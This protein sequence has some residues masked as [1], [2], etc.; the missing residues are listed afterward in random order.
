M[1]RVP[2]VEVRGATKTF[3]AVRALRAVDFAVGAGEIVGLIG[4]N[5]A[6]K[7][8]LVRVLAGATRPDGGDL[9][10]DGAPAAFHSPRDA[11]AAGIALVPQEI[12]LIG[13]QSVAD[14]IFL[15]RPFARRGI[16]NDREMRGRARE[17][18]ARVGLAEL[19]PRRP[20]RTLTPVQQKLV[21]FAQALSVDPR[22]LILD[23]P[24]AALPT[25]IARQ[26]EPVVSET[27]RRGSGVIY[28]SHRLDEISRLSDAVVAMRDGEIVG[29]LAQSD[30]TV[31]R[32][33]YL[34]GGKALEEEPVGSHGDVGGEIVL[35]AANVSGRRVRDASLTV[36][37]GE[38]LG[39]GGVYGSGRSELLRLLAG[40]Q[41]LR[42]GTIEF[43]GVSR[44]RS[45]A[46]AAALGIGYLPEGRSRMIFPGM[47]VR[48]N[49]VITVLRRL[50]FPGGIITGGR[51]RRAAEQIMAR[52]GVVGAP[53]APIRTLSGGNQQKVCLARWLLRGVSL[54]V[55]DEPTVGVDV[56][57]RA[58][59]HNVLR[60]LAEEQETAIVVAC[61][62][63]EELVLLCDRVVT[64][65][66][67]QVAR[68][69]RAPFDADAVVAASYSMGVADGGDTIAKV[70]AK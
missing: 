43:G 45:P 62:E 39:I 2:L 23:E 16:M 25:E 15:G 54:L 31:E 17:L 37:A 34:I 6:G 7:S 61:A 69:L 32:M 27:A 67:G 68:E 24:T 38:I 35:T 28:V 21:S 44:I 13:S 22:V 11:L 70:E 55:L 40:V 50:A 49:A 10:V 41:Q 65:V 63:P 58:E 64:L 5:G 56:H 12:A 20:V 14:N 9:L 53:E 1:T 57:A 42:S 48:T 3:G 59:I 4:A 60:A 19:D 47:P 52:L 18:L 66:D 46:A 29:R 30:A 36:R 26:L 8:T 51:E 33:V